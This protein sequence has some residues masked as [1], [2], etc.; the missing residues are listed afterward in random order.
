MRAAGGA[1]GGSGAL[2]PVE[3]FGLEE[4][5]HGVADAGIARVA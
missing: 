4:L 1:L 3:A 5:E 2:G